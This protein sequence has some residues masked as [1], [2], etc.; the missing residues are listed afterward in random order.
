MVILA[1]L[2]PVG[3]AADVAAVV[4][5]AG[6]VDD[7]S[8]GQ[9][10]IGVTVAVG[11]E[12]DVPGGPAG[13]EHPLESPLLG[14]CGAVKAS[15]V[16]LEAHD[17]GVRARVADDAGDVGVPQRTALLQHGDSIGV[18]R[19][20]HRGEGATDRHSGV[21]SGHRDGTNQGVVDLRGEA[22]D[23]VRLEI[24]RTGALPRG[25]VDLGEGTTQVQ[26]GAVRREL[27]IH[28]RAVGR[29]PQRLALACSI[30]RRHPVDGLIVDGGEVAAEVDGGAVG[31]RLDRIDLAIDLGCPVQQRTGRD[32][33]GHGVVTRRLVLAGGRPCR[34]GVLELPDD[35]DG[36]AHHRLVQN[37]AV[38]LSSGQRLRGGE[39]NLP[40]GGGGRGRNSRGDERT[41]GEGEGGQDR[42]HTGGSTERM[43]E[44][45]VLKT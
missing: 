32:V 10:V 26:G 34:A 23:L 6:D 43:H 21:V 38:H 2:L 9:H 7:V 13:A 24:H 5:V 22:V 42:P 35:V 45:S 33:E 8:G 1:A 44:C 12:V 14:V 19:S 41:E 25:G 4:R 20:V 36:I 40:R 11:H 16:R 27:Q 29:G 30:H 28:H 17:A 15:G 18:G 39:S 3:E 31:R 37:D